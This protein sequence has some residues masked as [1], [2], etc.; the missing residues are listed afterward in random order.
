MYV[1]T[2]L[3]RES[4]LKFIGDSILRRRRSLALMNYGSEKGLVHSQ[5]TLSISLEKRIC[6]FTLLVMV[7]SM[8]GFVFG[9]WLILTKS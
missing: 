2:I 7:P 5:A 1:I 9:G 8:G 3:K 6:F 4:K